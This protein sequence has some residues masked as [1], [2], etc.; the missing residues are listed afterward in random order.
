M[1]EN[2]TTPVTECRF[3]PPLYLFTPPTLPAYH[4]LRC[5][6]TEMK[7]QAKFQFSSSHPSSVVLHPHFTPFPMMHQMTACAR[8][9]IPV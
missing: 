4:T 7:I 3:H 8:V 2:F 6:R 9:H 1:R 5:P